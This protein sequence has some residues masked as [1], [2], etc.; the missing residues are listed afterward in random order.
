MEEAKEAPRVSGTRT[1]LMRLAALTFALLIT[2]AILAYRDQL[3]GLAVYGY[4]GIFLISILGNATLLFP[5]PGLL[6]TFVG[7]GLFNPLI[8]GFIAGAGHTL[9]ELTGYLAGYGG[10]AIIEDQ[11]LYQRLVSWMER[12]GDLT[13]FIFAA[14]PNPVFDVA[15]IAAGALRFPL[16]RFLLSC[17]A[18]K[19]L[20]TL[21]VAL[22]GTQAIHFLEQLPW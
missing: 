21:A 13:I 14:I 10:Q 5:V 8:V 18:G 7:G 6:A 3:K 12:H 2:A 22:A 16:W 9:G 19:T 17:W 15:G 4:G 1:T 20:K 11:R